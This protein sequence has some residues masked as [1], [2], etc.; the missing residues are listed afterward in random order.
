MVPSGREKVMRATSEKGGAPR[1]KTEVV[2]DS[3]I[4]DKQVAIQL[5]TK[6]RRSRYCNNTENL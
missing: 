6:L 4:T 1:T 3:S 5:G 2:L